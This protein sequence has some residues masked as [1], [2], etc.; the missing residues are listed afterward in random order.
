[1]LYALSVPLINQPS[2]QV[3]AKEAFFSLIN[4]LKL[5]M[6]DRHLISIRTLSNGIEFGL[7]HSLGPE[8]AFSV[9]PFAG[10][11]Y[12]LILHQRGS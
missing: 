7:V 6:V 12:L 9:R 8:K 10:A 11:P 5:V 2:S 3:C 4:D 1:M